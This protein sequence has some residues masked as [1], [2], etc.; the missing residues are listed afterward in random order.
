MS[1]ETFATA[2]N[3]Y[4]R[5]KE[6]LDRL[7]GQPH[8]PYTFTIS[9]WSDG[10]PE[11]DT[12]QDR[13]NKLNQYLKDHPDF[14]DAPRWIKERDDL[15]A[16][17][18][19][20]DVQKKMREQHMDVGIWLKQNGYGD[21]S[22]EEI[23]DDP[24]KHQF[25]MS[26]TPEQAQ[27]LRNLLPYTKRISC[28]QIDYDLSSFTAEEQ[29][30]LFISTAAVMRSVL[31][32]I[33]A[34]VKGPELAK[35]IESLQISSSQLEDLAEATNSRDFL[36]AVQQLNTSKYTPENK[37]RQYTTG[38]RFPYIHAIL[39]AET[40]WND[41]PKAA[42]YLDTLN[43]FMLTYKNLSG[44]ESSSRPENE[45]LGY[46]QGVLSKV[47]GPLDAERLPYRAQFRVHDTHE[48]TQRDIMTEMQTVNDEMRE[49]KS[50]LD[51]ADH[52]KSLQ[53][54]YDILDNE[55]KEE[56][57][58]EKERAE[59]LKQSAV[60]S[61]QETI[62]T[63]HEQGLVAIDP[64][65]HVK[66]EMVNYSGCVE[67]IIT[68]TQKDIDT[69][70]QTDFFKDIWV[71]REVGPGMLIDALNGNAEKYPYF[72]GIP[73]PQPKYAQPTPPPPAVS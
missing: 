67:I 47:P 59:S 58:Q 27:N 6:L 9:P 52:V 4:A 65:R 20:S 46:L 63:L 64:V 5:A 11:I 23:P 29:Q 18:A 72:P 49:Y 48:R 3:P 38:L 28:E 15:Q 30:E 41:D 24:F 31:G 51:F 62:T 33:K 37:D 69:L 39:V 19:E 54:K 14:P 34:K 57:K 70:K 26:L 56:F 21:V 66:R 32:Y 53:E 42:N 13:I 36:K 43:N 22:L 17:T 71:R 50:N 61:A 10:K 8:H 25:T 12:N 1:K 73:K 2:A 16:S 55:R 44:T 40:Y 68:A 60:Q 35:R 7:A 45:I